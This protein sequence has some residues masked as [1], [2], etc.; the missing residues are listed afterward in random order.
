MNVLGVK[1]QVQDL[2]GFDY[3][4]TDV[5]ARLIR[6]INDTRREI[7]RENDWNFALKTFQISLPIDY[8]TGT[9]SISQDSRVVTGVGTAFTSTM[10]GRYI[11]FAHDTGGQEEWYKISSVTSTTEIILEATYI[12]S[13]ASGEDFVIRKVYHRVPGNARKIEHLRKFSSPRLVEKIG[14]TRFYEYN[15]NINRTGTKRKFT[16]AGVYGN[17]DTYTTGTL[18]GTSGTKALTGSSTEWLANVVPGDKITIASVNYY[19]ESVNSDTSISL[20]QKLTATTLGA[21]YTVTSDP[22]SQM[23]RFDRQSTNRIL[24]ELEYYERCYDL[25]GDTDEDYL[26]RNFPMLIIDGVVIFEKR[27]SDD[28]S[29]SAADYQKWKAGIR[30]AIQSTSDDYMWVPKFHKYRP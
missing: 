6:F 27:A 28:A 19:V 4:D 3:T 24:I 23:I 8:E 22:D 14:G 11:H 21:T 10:V 2:T 17:E 29:W 5:A 15:S 30:D 7:Y 9:V 13:D 1:I 12:D 16:V 25:L 26:L 20:Y 18:S